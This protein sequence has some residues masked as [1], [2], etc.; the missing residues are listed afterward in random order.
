MDRV[1]IMLTLV[2]LSGCSNAFS[3][4]YYAQTEGIDVARLSVAGAGGKDPTLFRGT[5]EETDHLRMLED[6]FWMIGYSSF[7]AGAQSDK[8]A[9]RQARKVHASVVLLYVSYTNTVSGVTPLMLPNNQSS[10]T[11]LYGNA[12]GAGGSTTFSG[13]A[14]TTTQGSQ[15]A[16]MPYIVNRY[17]YMATYWV[18]MKPPIFGVFVDD[19]SAEIRQKI[20]SNKGQCVMA[21]VKNSPAFRADILRGDILRKIGDAEVSDRESFFGAA[22]RYAGQTVRV[23]IYRD[24]KE[25]EKDVTLNEGL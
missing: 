9:I 5:D 21:V 22:D 24:G 11:S 13:T 7:N 3:K 25:I 8:G 6:G 2:A 17:D 16:Y 12:Y 19:L 18:K 10:T 1:W 14:Y 15:I 20:G 23:L 4:F